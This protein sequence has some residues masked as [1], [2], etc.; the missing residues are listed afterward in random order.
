MNNRQSI[1]ILAKLAP[2]SSL[3]ALCISAIVALGLGMLNL[4]SVA[5]CL[6]VALGAGSRLRKA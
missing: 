5:G 6:V 1:Q 3:I 4:A 2:G